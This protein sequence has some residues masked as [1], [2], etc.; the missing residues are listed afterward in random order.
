MYSVICLIEFYI[1]L[2]EVVKFILLKLFIKYLFFFEVRG[3]LSDFLS[4]H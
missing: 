3:M 2:D 1:F 4:I